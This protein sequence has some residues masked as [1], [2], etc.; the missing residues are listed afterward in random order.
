MKWLPITTPIERRR[1]HVW[2]DSAPPG[3]KIAFRKG[4][5]RSLD[6]NALMWAR[7]TEISRQVVWHGMKL[8]PDD[9]KDM[10]TAVLRKA[11]AV[12][13]I[14]GGFVVLGLHTSNMTKSE[15]ADML[16]L[17]EAFAAEH[18]VI[19]EDQANG[20]QGIPE[21]GEGG[22]DQTRHA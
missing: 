9:Y 16:T 7:L 11:V 5:A 15:M 22:G 3:T 13:G 8:T 6:Q 2:I 1:A 20:S 14:D 17:M 19:F 18:G 10:F 21:V 12:P 4:D